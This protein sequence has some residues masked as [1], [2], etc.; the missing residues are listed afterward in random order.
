MTEREK[1]ASGMAKG[2]KGA[3]KMAKELKM[4]EGEEEA[5][6]TPTLAL[7]V[8]LKHSPDHLRHLRSK[9]RETSHRLPWEIF[10]RCAVRL[11]QDIDQDAKGSRPLMSTPP[12]LWPQTGEECLSGST[13]RTFLSPYNV[14]KPLRML[15]MVQ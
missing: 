1:G 3:D 10:G 14:G 9:R 7:G 4:A 5:D 6:G 11:G 8:G 15:L 13:S 2:E 12:H